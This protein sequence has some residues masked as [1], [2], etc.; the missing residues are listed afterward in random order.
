MSS[1]LIIDGQRLPIPDDIAQDDNSIRRAL[2]PM[3]TQL[4]NGSITRA[5]ANDKTVEITVTKQAGRKGYQ[6][7]LHSLDCQPH[8][9]NPAVAF[10]FQ[11]H[12][13]FDLSD[14]TSLIHVMTHQ[15]I[16]EEA[17]QAGTHELN[18]VAT[19]FKRLLF[20][21]STHAHAGPISF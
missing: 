10:T 17:I 21:A 18:T 7:I 14:P 6:E 4:A 12:Q 16:I 5:I 2:G 8:H 11:L 3:F 1:V 20:S 19:I 15:Q 9:I 13:R